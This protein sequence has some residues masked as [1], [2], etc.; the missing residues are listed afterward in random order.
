MVQSSPC[1]SWVPTDLGPKVSIL[2]TAHSPGLGGHLHTSVSGV[3]AAGLLIL[4]CRE[5]VW[6]DAAAIMVQAWSHG[7]CSPQP[8]APP[9]LFSFWLGWPG[10]FHRCL[11]ESEG[12]R[13]KEGRGRMIQG[14]GAGEPFDAT[15]T[16]DAKNWAAA[17]E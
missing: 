11:A 9:I 1:A 3:Q 17:R 6:Q 16:C 13:E 8:P 5:G 7:C 2:C 14:L 15:D 12:D 4:E 10:Q